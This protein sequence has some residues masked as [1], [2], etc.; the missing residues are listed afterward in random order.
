VDPDAI[1]ATDAEQEL[2]QQ[3]IPFALSQAN[4]HFRNDTRFDLEERQGVALYAL[5]IAAKK[6][7]P[8]KIN[9]LT[10]TTYSFGSY[11]Q[12][13]IWD[14][15]RK[16]AY[17]Y[18]SQMSRPSIG[19]KNTE[20]ELDQQTLSEHEYHQDNSDVEYQDLLAKLYS[21]LDKPEVAVLK[22]ILAGK[23]YQD[24]LLDLNRFKKYRNR[25]SVQLVS[26]LRRSI[27]EK[28]RRN[29]WYRE[30]GDVD[31][32]RPEERQQRGLFRI[33][34]DVGVRQLYLFEPIEYWDEYGRWRKDHGRQAYDVSNGQCNDSLP[35]WITIDQAIWRRVSRSRQSTRSRHRRTKCDRRQLYFFWFAR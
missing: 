18:G 13:V 32:L 14:H 7:D 11:A 28:M 20:L 29:C 9:P 23:R 25:K 27:I 26:K 30:L 12:R 6:F 34:F 4:Q 2:I 17:K 24:I 3:W 33:I 31:E 21:Q 22:G 16:A 35:E 8:L 5:T 1:P 15:L 19:S 10:G